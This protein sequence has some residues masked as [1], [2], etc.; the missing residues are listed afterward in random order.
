M[1]NSEVNALARNPFVDD[2]IQLDIAQNFHLKAREY[3][4]SNLNLIPEARDILWSG[5]SHVVKCAL[6]MTGHMDAFP[7]R[8]LELYEA[9]SP[10]YWKDVP[11]R[12]GSTFIGN[13]WWYADNQER[14]TPSKL[15]EI[16]YDNHLSDD[17]NW[18]VFG[19]TREHMIARL[20][21]HSNL[22]SRVA[23]KMTTSDSERIRKSGF[24][25]LV[26]IKKR[27]K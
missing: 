8:V 2:R 27:E 18:Q 5:R 20:S 11:W 22:N 16:I 25:A 24:E 14:S 4:A 26:S 12:L 23:I 13:Y 3:L 17:S 9:K 21:K 15:L 1:T 7:E 6:A 19:G 10:G